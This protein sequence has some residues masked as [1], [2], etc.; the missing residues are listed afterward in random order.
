MNAIFAMSRN[1]VIGKDGGLPWHLPADLAFFK[2]VTM[3]HSIIMGRKTWESIGR[4]LPGRKNIVV[5][6]DMQYKANGCQVCHS[7]EEVEKLVKDQE[8][9]V[10]GGAEIYDLFHAN[11]EKIYVTYIDEDIDGDTYYDNFQFFGWKII[12]EETCLVDDKNKLPRSVRIYQK[13]SYDPQLRMNIYSFED[14]P[15]QNI[16][17]EFEL[18]VY[19]KGDEFGYEKIINESFGGEHNFEVEIVKHDHYESEGVFFVFYGEEAVATSTAIIDRSPANKI[20]YLHMVGAFSGYKGKR[21]GFEVSLACLLKMKSEGMTECTLTTD[22]FRFPAIVTYLNLGF[23]PKIVHENQYERW[24]QILMQ[25]KRE[26]LIP[27]VMGQPSP[28]HI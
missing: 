28:Q 9:F 8:S 19:Q 5:T 14:L 25:V 12:E 27:Y 3:G 13:L 24:K 15:S 20:G 2:K 10:I 6:K 1:G 21:L 18:K 11:I 17:E 7:V 23:L 26:D 22:D 4:P 16:P